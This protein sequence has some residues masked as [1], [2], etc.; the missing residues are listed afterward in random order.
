M[1]YTRGAPRVSEVRMMTPEQ[2]Q[3][4]INFII[5]CQA[6]IEANL[7]R[8]ESGLEQER[9]ER[10]QGTG[11]GQRLMREITEILQKQAAVLTIQSSRMDH[12]DRM[13]REHEERMRE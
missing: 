2:L 6:R 12:S 5:E 13:F 11:E 3:N 8:L 1:R 7:D 9:Q 4:T 10:I